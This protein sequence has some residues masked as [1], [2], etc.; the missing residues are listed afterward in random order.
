MRVKTS[1]C[2]HLRPVAFEPNAYA[3]SVCT[4]R[5]PA[6]GHFSVG[7]VSF[8]RPSSVAGLFDSQRRRQ[9]CFLP[10]DGLPLPLS[11]SNFSPHHL[12]PATSGCGCVRREVG[13]QQGA[14]AQRARD[15]VIS[16]WDARAAGMCGC[17][18]GTAEALSTSGCPKSSTTTASSENCRELRRG[19]AAAWSWGRED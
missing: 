8:M 16:W 14:G 7:G 5:I 9:S 1:A 2:F 13:S 18:A 3:S 19:I 12:I 4:A 6:L 10:R 17:A 11:L 15:G